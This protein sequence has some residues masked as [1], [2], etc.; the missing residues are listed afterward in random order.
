MKRKTAIKKLM[1]MGYSRNDAETKL[2]W[3]REFDW[4]NETVVMMFSVKYHLQ[5]LGTTLSNALGSACLVATEAV[6]GWASRV[7][8]A[9]Y[10]LGKEAANYDDH[11]ISGLLEDE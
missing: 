6:S 4:T 1:G 10:N 5:N 2:F 11:D 7:H 8:Q 3:A 9:A